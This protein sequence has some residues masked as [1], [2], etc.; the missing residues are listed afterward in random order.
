MANMES[1]FKSTARK[2]HWKRFTTFARAEDVTLGQAGR[3]TRALSAVAAFAVVASQLLACKPSISTSRSAAV[4]AT[5]ESFAVLGGSTVTN[6]GPTT[7]VGD[8]GI[9]PGLAVTGFPPAMVTGGA[10]HAGDAVALQAQGDLTRAYN[11]LA[12]QSCSR[13]LTGQDLGGLTLTPGVYCFSSSAQLTGALTLD[14]QGDASSVFVFQIRST[15]TTAG[16]ASVLVKNGAR[17]CNAFWQVGS[18]ATL[19]T[20]TQFVGSILALTSI[21]LTTGVQVFGRALARNGAVTMDTNH[22]DVGACADEASGGSTDGTANGGGADANTED[23]PSKDGGATDGAQSGGGA[24]GSAGG[25]GAGGGGHAGGGDHADCV[26]CGGTHVD[27]KTDHENCG[28]CGKVCSWNLQC[29]AGSCICTATTC[30][31][32]CVKVDENPKNCGACGHVCTANQWCDHGSCTSVCAGTICDGWC[33]NLMRNHDACGACGHKCGSAESCKGGVCVC[34][35]TMCGS[36]CVD[37]TSS[38][39]DCGTCGHACQ[40]SECCTDSKCVPLNH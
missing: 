14:A 9:S 20:G 27:L 5:A 39:I 10:I 36:A 40:E 4:L 23:A 38:A 32:I 30:G 11:T 34:I 37:L 29:V 12:G 13:D 6:T 25:G 18:S 7:I 15:L 3:M 22:L 28:A 21:S 1:L 2:A 26:L 8:V 33:T 19:G 17:S 16:N 35:G 31:S 24:G